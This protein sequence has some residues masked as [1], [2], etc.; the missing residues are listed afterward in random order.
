MSFSVLT[1]PAGNP[2]TRR[3]AG[4]SLLEVLIAASLFTVAAGVLLHELAFSYRHYSL[5]RDDWKAALELWN[6]AARWRA[7]GTSSTSE[8]A[9][10]RGRTAPL[11][12]IRFET[13]SAG[14]TL[15][16]EVWHVHP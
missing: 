13:A 2:G 9:Q 5:A 15:T 7:G 12:R 16:W 4:F 8:N 10:I 14:R 6:R 11:H 3:R 1:R